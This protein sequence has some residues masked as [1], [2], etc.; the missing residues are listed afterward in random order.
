MPDAASSAANRSVVPKRAVV[1]GAA[2]G[3]AGHQR[4]HRR[5]A[6]EGLHPGLLVDAEHH[7][8]V[9]RVQVQPHYVADLV[10]EL[11]VRRHLELLCE[12][13]LEPERLPDGVHRPRGDARLSGHRPRRPVRRAHRRGLQGLD[14]HLL[15]LRVV[16]GARRPRARLVREPLEAAL[17]EPRAPLR[18]RRRVTP[19]ICRDLIV[20]AALGRGQHDPAPQRQRLRRL[21]PPRPPLQ[22]LALLAAQ[23]HSHRR[24]SPPRAHRRPRS[25]STT[26]RYPNHNI[27][28]TN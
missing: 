6:V 13:R 19:Q 27:N 4:Q 1:V 3:R 12:V 26:P 17:S 28:A 24:P 21:R 7:R 11:R 22:H 15:D 18:H 5:G 20:G 2:L 14:D 16:D 9:R 23:L 8:R 25:S 10:D